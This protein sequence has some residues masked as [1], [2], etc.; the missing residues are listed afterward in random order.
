MVLKAPFCTNPSAVFTP[1]MSPVKS[2]Q[3]HAKKSGRYLSFYFPDLRFTGPGC[4][5]GELTFR[6]RNSVRNLPAGPAGLCADQACVTHRVFAG[7]P[8]AFFDRHVSPQMAR[9]MM[10]E[11]GFKDAK[12]WGEFG[13][14]ITGPVTCPPSSSRCSRP[15]WMRRATRAGGGPWRRPPW[16]HS[17]NGVLSSSPN[18]P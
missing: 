1:G 3:E 8:A 5:R 16:P 12:H 7:Q 18:S 6:I 14:Q 2:P 15:A 4:W 9:A 17:R 13:A 10:L 11:G